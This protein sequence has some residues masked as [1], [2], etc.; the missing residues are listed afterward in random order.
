MSESPKFHK[1]LKIQR[2]L[3]ENIKHIGNKIHTTLK[4]FEEIKR[5]LDLDK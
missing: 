1:L 5:S 3:D 2:E 4:I